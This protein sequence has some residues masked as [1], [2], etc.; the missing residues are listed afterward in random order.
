MIDT[1]AATHVKYHLYSIDSQLGR[2][3]DNSSIQSRLFRLY[4]HATIVHCLI[5]KLTMRTGTVEALD[6]VTSA[7]AMCLILS[8]SDIEEE[9]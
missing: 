9:T 8:I 5:D 4:L 1:A 7:I 2:L 6:V 3:I